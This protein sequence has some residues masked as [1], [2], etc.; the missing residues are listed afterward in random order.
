MKLLTVALLLAGFIG[1]AE[2]RKGHGGS[3]RG[4]PS[5]RDNLRKREEIHEDDDESANS[6]VDK[7][8]RDHP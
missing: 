7:P 8:E 6:P 2:Q 4:G 3:S 5:A 1:L